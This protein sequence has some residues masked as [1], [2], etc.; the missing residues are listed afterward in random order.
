M[1][2]KAAING[3]RS[4]FEHSGVPVSAREQAA[5]AIGCLKAGADAIHLH[6]RSAAG[7]ESLRA[8]DVARTLEAVLAVC[9]KS[10]IGVTTGA[11]ILPDTDA[12]LRAV[13]SW[14]VFPGFASVNFS[15][16]GAAEIATLLLSRGVDIEAGLIDANSA[17]GF[18]DSGLVDRCLRVLIEPQEQEQENALENVNEIESLLDSAKVELPRLLHGTEATTWAML[19]EAIVRGFGG[20]IGFEDTLTLPD[21]RVARS[22]EELVTEALRRVRALTTG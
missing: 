4:K 15:E 7:V 3:G 20:R 21:G 5:A 19:A 16:D 1:L 2:I 8:E 9:P 6:V 22:N 12:R 10:Q 13:G 18:V 14:E 11:W 17:R